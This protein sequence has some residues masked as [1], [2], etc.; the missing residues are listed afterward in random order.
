MAFKPDPDPNAWKNENNSSMAYIM[1][2]DFVKKRLKSPG[3]ADFPFGYSD[4][5]KSIGK[6]QYKI[7]AYVDAQ[8]SFGA[9]VRTRFTGIIEQT[10]KERWKLIS[11]DIE[12]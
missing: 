6:F 4:Y 12:N 7:T 2:Q 1:M 8:N 5:T 11:L 3:T 10:D 9:L